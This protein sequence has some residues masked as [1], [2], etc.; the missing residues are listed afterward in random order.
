MKIKKKV[1]AFIS[2]LAV[3]GAISFGGANSASA[4]SDSVTENI[5]QLPGNSIQSNIW[6]SATAFNQK[7]SYQ[8]SAKFIG[9][10]PPNADWVKTAWAIK[11]N[12]LGVSIGG[13]SG[14][15]SN[16][17]TLTG[18][19]TNTNTWISDYAGSYNISGVPISGG[20]DNTA[21]FLAKGVKRSASSSIFR[22]Y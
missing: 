3:A 15:T 9:K 8:V 2:T 19:W 11:A 1:V 20:G 21:S 18:T 12:G 5:P 4:Y 14:G 22:L 17:N 16:G 6:M 13:V 10:N 7:Q